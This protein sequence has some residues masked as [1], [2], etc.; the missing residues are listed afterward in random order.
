M[1]VDVGHGGRWRPTPQGDP[2]EDRLLAVAGVAAFALFLASF[3]PQP[4]TWLVFAELMR[5]AAIVAGLMALL[6][7]ER[8][9]E[10]YLSGW[11]QAAIFFFFSFLGRFQVDAE[12]VLA[13]AETLSAATSG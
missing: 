3:V 7:G 5:W 13:A 2:S 1:L 8:L 10:P 4:F 6:R 12:A 11:D 9:F